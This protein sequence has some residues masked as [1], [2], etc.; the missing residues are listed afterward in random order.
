MAPDVAL[1]IPPRPE[2]VLGAGSIEQLPAL[3]RRLGA[4]GA[5]VVTDHGVVVAGIA[6]RVMRHFVAAGVPADVF[7]G[8]AANPSAADVT[9]G[10][11]RLRG[12]GA[13]PVAV[14]AA[15]WR[16]RDRRGQ[17][18]RAAVGQRQPARPARRP[19]G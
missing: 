10:V 3:V 5:F 8:V 18:H 11:E 16:I 19:G 7:D 15:G 4:A 6:A 14:V 17:G 1:R 13:R 2:M 9:A 12:A